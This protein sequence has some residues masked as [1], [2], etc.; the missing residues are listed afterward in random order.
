MKAHIILLLTPLIPVLANAQL[1][2]K[3]RQQHDTTYTTCYHTNG[4][5]ATVEVW[6]SSEKRWGHITGFTSQG[7]ELFKH[8]LRRV[9]GYASVYLQ[10]HSNGQVSRAEYSSAP[11][12][13]I[14]FWHTITTWDEQ[15][16]QTSYVD[17]SQPDGH[18]V[19]VTPPHTEPYRQPEPAACATPYL[20]LFRIHNT[21]RHTITIRYRNARPNWE[22]PVR[23]T[24]LRIAPKQEFVADSFVFYKLLRQTESYEVVPAPG[25]RSIKPKRII[26]AQPTE[27]KN[28][29][30]YTW[31]LLPE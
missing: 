24:L 27:A 20:T 9:A 3:T 15:G 6:Y 8:Q 17:L 13:G 14:Q 30:V 19:L 25:K 28:R 16:N 10:Y 21:T 11:D 26:L 18:P 31:Y 4:K 1:R 2:C 12:G 7:K 23:D 22:L 5:P 29:R